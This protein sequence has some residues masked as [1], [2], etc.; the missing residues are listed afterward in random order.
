V[1]VTL[2]FAQVHF[3]KCMEQRRWSCKLQCLHILFT[4]HQ[5]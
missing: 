5:R 4:S 3:A 2:L 1:N